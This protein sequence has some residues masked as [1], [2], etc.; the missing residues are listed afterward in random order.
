MD[1]KQNIRNM[2]VIAHVDHGMTCIWSISFTNNK[3]LLNCGGWFFLANSNILFK[4]LW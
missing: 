3:L 1:L 2:S 4:W